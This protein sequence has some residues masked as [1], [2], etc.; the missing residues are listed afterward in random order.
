MLIRLLDQTV[1]PFK[2]RLSFR[3][4]RNTI[5]AAGRELSGELQRLLPAS[6]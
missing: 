6:Y 4:A 3:L 5:V 2:K 1:I